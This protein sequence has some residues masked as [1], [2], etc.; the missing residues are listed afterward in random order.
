[1][2][3]WSSSE[4]TQ[5]D[6]RAWVLIL[7]SRRGFAFAPEA[8]RS[9]QSARTALVRWTIDLNSLADVSADLPRYSLTS[10]ITA[11]I[12]P[13][14][15][16]ESDLRAQLWVCA[17]FDTSGTIVG[18]PEI[19]LSAELADAWVR[20]SGLD[21]PAR[22][23]AAMPNADPK[24]KFRI[25]GSEFVAVASQVKVVSWSLLG[26]RR[27]PSRTLTSLYEVEI[28]ANY[29]H[30]VRASIQA[31]RGLSREELVDEIRDVFPHFTLQDRR[32]IDV[33]WKLIW[34]KEDEP[35]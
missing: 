22:K 5:L 24:C 17:V 4:R 7:G 6:G 31:P 12:V 18:P 14:I 2:D 34:M 1:M 10:E 8:H 3:D 13:L 23:L 15:V 35:S 29:T 30:I 27:V 21:D 32:L 20:T 11:Q 33:S 19:Q 9:R 16:D 28:S 26:D 25:G